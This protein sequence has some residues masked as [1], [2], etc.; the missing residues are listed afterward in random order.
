MVSIIFYGKPNCV[1]NNKQKALL[2]AAGHA[3]DD[4]DILSHPWTPEELEP[5]FNGHEVCDWFNK[6]APAIKSGSLSVD[7]F[8][9]KQAL[10]A[11][12]EDP[13]L[14]RRPLMDV[15]GQKLC[16]FRFEELDAM[17]GLEPAA[18]H[19]AEMQNLQSQN[20]TTCPFLATTTNCDQQETQ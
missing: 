2:R 14:I 17:I 9:A 18:G 12:I 7:S 10:D 20:I 4:R 19:E 15:E 16:G 11:M 3:V 1:N 13:L 5:Y 6:T 8:S